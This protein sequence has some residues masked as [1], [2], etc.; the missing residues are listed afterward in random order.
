MKLILDAVKLSK[1]YKELIQ[2]TVCDQNNADYML[3]RCDD[4]PGESPL[5][6]YLSH[7]SLLDEADE[8]SHISFR[9]WTTTDRAEMFDRILT[10]ER[11]IDLLIHRIEK[12]TPHSFITRE[13]ANYLN[14]VKQDLS[15]EKVIVLGD[16]VQNY[17][18]ILQND[19]GISLELFSM[20][21][22]SHCD[23]LPSKQQHSGSFSLLYFK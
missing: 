14:Q 1:S 2:L 15:G 4:C 22:T 8:S 21:F 9:E 20:Y 23:I 7:L 16:F 3:Q 19:T 10:L 12:L 17:Q 11:F 5:R 18:F 13:Q 6:E